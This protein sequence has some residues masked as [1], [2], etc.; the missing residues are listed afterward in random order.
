LEHYEGWLPVWMAPDQLVVA[1]VSAA[2]D[3]YA[4]HVQNLL[5]DA[6][7]RATLDTRSERL[8]RKIID[9]RENC[10][11]IFVAVGERDRKNQTVSVRQRDGSQRTIELAE[12]V[13]R[14][15][16]EARSPFFKT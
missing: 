15:R 13:A 16:E 10:I 12:V 6:G 1:S 14:I 7:I 3:A 2:S 9:A 8:P 11:P 5:L 4:C